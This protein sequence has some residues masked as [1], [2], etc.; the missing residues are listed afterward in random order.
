VLPDTSR[1]DWTVE[2]VHALPDDGYRYEVIDGE[3]LVSPAPTVFHQRIVSRLNRA[4]GSY[5][6]RCGLECLVAPV[7][8]IFSPRQ[9]LQ[10]DLVV[11][12]VND[13]RLP[14]VTEMARRLVLAVEVLSPSTAR[15][16]RYRKRPLLQSEQV[17]ECWI[18]DPGGRFVERWR[19]TDAEPEVWH[20]AIEWAPSAGIEPLSL[21]L[22]R[23]FGPTLG[24]SR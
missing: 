12:R 9:L 7:D 6:E 8:V 3:L 18:V 21:D 14:E 13:G 5:A 17:A 2:E 1:H 16:D 10:P 20:E 22:V 15:A 11:F 23:L 4:L 19:P 24:E